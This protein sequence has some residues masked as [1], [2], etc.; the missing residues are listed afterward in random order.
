[1]RNELKKRIDED[2][3]LFDDLNKN[4]KSSLKRK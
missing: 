1:M 3:K 4:L 2:K